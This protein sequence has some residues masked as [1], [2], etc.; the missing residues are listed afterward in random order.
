MAMVVLVVAVA[1]FGAGLIASGQKGRAS[2]NNAAG[3]T[4]KPQPPTPPPPPVEP[5]FVY[6][7]QP[8]AYGPVEVSIDGV[9]I[10]NAKISGF[11]GSEYPTNR[12]VLQLWFNIGSVQEF[13]RKFDY[14]GIG[15]VQI[16]DDAGNEY[17]TIELDIGSRIAG[18]TNEATIYPGNVV[19]TS[20]IFEPPVESADH[21]NVVVSVDCDPP[22]SKAF[23]FRIP[24]GMLSQY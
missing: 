1:S 17:R 18:S 11:F 9:G 20:M 16:T 2:G 6:A 23:R 12:V 7:G 5:P 8:M 13:R 24:K 19:R 15:H 21:L 10:G 14:K 22:M 4:V 3:E